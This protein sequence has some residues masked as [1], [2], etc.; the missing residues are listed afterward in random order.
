M[1][2]QNRALSQ[3]WLTTNYILGHPNLSG[4]RVK[5]NAVIRYFYWQFYYRIFRSAITF[6]LLPNL[7]LRCYPHSHSASA[8]LYCG[9]YD[10]DEM[11]FL[12]RYLRPEDCFLD[13]GANIGIYTLLAAHKIKHGKIYS[14]EPNPKNYERLLENIHINQFHQVLPS[15]IALS[16]RQGSVTLELNQSDSTSRIS[17]DGS[18]AVGVNVPTDTLDALF[19]Q[20]IP[21]HLVAGKIDVE[22]AEVMVFRGAKRLL[23]ERLPIVWIVE[24]LGDLNDA[25]KLSKDTHELI[26][27]FE[28]QGYIFCQYNAASNQLTEISI[29]QKQGNNIFAIARTKLD[30]VRNRLQCSDL[31]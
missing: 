3:F 5:I 19:Q 14:F 8:A 31:V 23:T 22:G 26:D 20:E 2:S 29:S 10:Y 18:T 24:I 4:R 1:N 16:D 7:K 15:Q 9:L 21:D 30:F 28:D 17:L 11:M 13:I 6:E 12:L 27:I 25:S